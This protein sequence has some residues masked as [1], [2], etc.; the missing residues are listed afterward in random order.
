[1]RQLLQIIIHRLCQ[2]KVDAAIEVIELFTSSRRKKDPDV[3]SYVTLR[4][5]S[6]GIADEATEFQQQLIEQ[7]LLK[8]Q[9]LLDQTNE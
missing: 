3:Y 1:M 2:K 9:P 6:A 4:V 7:K 8:E 5:R